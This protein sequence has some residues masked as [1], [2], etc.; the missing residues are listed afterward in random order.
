M[1]MSKGTEVDRTRKQIIAEEI[2]LKVENEAITIDEDENSE[3]EF[4][5]K[6]KVKIEKN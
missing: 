6:K 3:P 2:E 4:Q 1:K 5:L